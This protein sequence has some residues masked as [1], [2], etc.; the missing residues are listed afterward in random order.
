MSIDRVLADLESRRDEAVETLLSFL[1]IPSISTD[2]AHA[3]DIATAAAWVRDQLRAAGLTAELVPTPGHPAI[4]A[5]S[6]PV[7]GKPT[8]LV[9]GHYDV[10]PVGE[11]EKWVSPP[12]EPAVRDGAIFARGAADDKGQVFTHIA[13]AAAWHRVAGALPVRLKFLIEGEEETGSA[14]IGALVHEHRE[15]LAC[16][17]VAVS[18]SGKLDAVT[19]A[20]TYSTKG[21]VYKDIKVFG[22]E[23]DLHSGT[24][25]GSVA[26]P[27]TVLTQ[28]VASLKDADDRVTIP[29]FYDDVRALTAEEQELIRAVAFDET[30]F[31]Q[32]LGSP[33]LF[34]EAGFGVLERR[35]ARPCLDVNGLYGGYRGPGAS[36]IIP[37]FAGAKVSMR[38]V[39]DQ[40]P[41]RISAAFDEAIRA[42]CPDTVRLTIETHGV[43]G[44][45]RAPIDSPGLRAAMRAVEAGF[46][47]KPAL[48]G[49]G[50]TLPILPMF[51]DELGADSLLMG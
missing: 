34:G 40:H 46:G 11:L 35:W 18:D 37:S 8:I 38:L 39:A 31:C 51:Q 29:G 25:G 7:D 15:R 50:G 24:F 48:I 6:G 17:Y 47:K 43:A 12:F 23:R 1:R 21:L 28:I 44:P 14:N 27:A 2:P 3:G 30:A 22:P 19:P 32:Q 5:D 41:A 10:Q 45:Y 9:Y 20:I 36:T 4:I 42:R 26:N 49:E 16:D 13:A 33:A